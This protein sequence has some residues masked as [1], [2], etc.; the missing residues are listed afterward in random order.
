MHEDFTRPTCGGQQADRR[1]THTTLIRNSHALTL[2]GQV[3]WARVIEDLR[4]NPHWLKLAQ[5]AED[6]LAKAGGLK[7]APK[8][9]TPEV[10]ALVL[11]YGDAKRNLPALVPSIINAPE[12]TPRKDLPYYWHS[13]C[14]AYDLDDGALEGLD[15][16]ERRSMVQA[17][18]DALDGFPHEVAS[19]LSI[20][21]DGWTVISGPKAASEAA[22]HHY[23]RAIRDKL[24][25]A[26]RILIPETGQTEIGRLRYMAAG[27]F[28]R[29]NPDNCPMVVD[30]PP[31]VEEAS[32]RA[33][34]SS[35]N[36]KRKTPEDWM[37]AWP[38]GLAPLVKRSTQWEGPCPSCALEAGD[39]GDDR[40][41]VNVAAPHHFGCR[42]CLDAK[43][44]PSMK[45]YW[46]VFGRGKGKADAVAEFLT[47]LHGGGPFHQVGAFIGEQLARTWRY[48]DRARGPHWARYRGGIWE[49]LTTQDR[50]LLDRVSAHRLRIAGQLEKQGMADL[51]K[52]LSTDYLW[53]GQKFRDSDWWA[54]L[55]SV[56]VGEVPDRA[57][58]HV[59]TP[60]GCVDLRTGEM[61]PHSP[62][63]GQRGKTA[64]RFL[65][66]EWPRLAEVLRK[67]FERVFSPG[68]QL[69]F[70]EL[71]G[72]S[73]TGE[74][75]THRGL[76]LVKGLWRSG[77]GAVVELQRISLGTRAGALG[78]DWFGRKSGD[79]DAETAELLHL[80]PD[81]I[82]VAEMGVDSLSQ[83]RKA[84][85][86][87]GGQD[88]LTARRP[89]GATITGKLAGLG[90]SS[91]VEVPRFDAE[92]G[93]EGRLVVLPTLGTLPEDLRRGHQEMFTQDLLDAVVTGAIL[94][95]GEAGVFDGGYI[96]PGGD[97][98]P[99]TAEVLAAMDPW[100]AWLTRLP[101]SWDTRLVEEA[102][103]EA[104]AE[105]GEEI[106]ET[107]WGGMINR[108]PRWTKRRGEVSGV[109]GTRLY[110]Q[111]NR[112]GDQGSDGKSA[113]K[114]YKKEKR[115][116]TT[117][118]LAAQPETPSEPEGDEQYHGPLPKFC[119]E[120]RTLLV[121][122]FCHACYRE[123]QD[124][125]R[126]P[127]PQA[128]DRSEP[129][130][131]SQQG[132]APVERCD[133]HMGYRMTEGVCQICV[134]EDA[135]GDAD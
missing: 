105:I 111:G 67:H 45:P 124:Q 5:A 66:A 10:K 29:H 43:G 65:P 60:G 17:A 134:H 130:G 74:A 2:G 83:R 126:S 11:D 103:L 37:A 115:D 7:K 123:W 75:A 98:D 76:V 8:D 32:P 36:R 54:G 31:A 21:N 96:P 64:G 68:V 56:C 16:E 101:D 9:A 73:L 90:W 61:H 135:V 81:S 69:I 100:A 121:G 120:H 13:G 93:I 18:L 50:S 122:A 106:T 88:V 80:Q 39:G 51:G 30:P 24:P 92:S 40:F 59:A 87:F 97:K 116:Q 3:S 38:P 99:V 22:H 46:S 20:S 35:G 15:G 110:L 119:P 125:E 53:N 118:T 55:R 27:R 34:R 42:H 131:Q 48:V 95:I 94:R 108:S 107:S 26:V 128:K 114:G 112:Q 129:S 12:K 117:V 132:G 109:R 85:A 58:F 127:V 23:L 77:K 14:Y 57:R 33:G 25:E 91:C 133:I 4:S 113:Y 47:A 41:H 1:I 52:K 19:G 49:D 70:L 28:A 62:E 84:L 89:H 72:L 44:Q 78:V 71:V 82:A 102:R 86:A 79:I 6:A 104:M 63:C